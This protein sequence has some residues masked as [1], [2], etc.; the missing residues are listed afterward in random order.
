MFNI[1]S[2]LTITNSIFWLNEDSSGTN[3]SAQIF[4]GTPV[5]NYNCIQ[6]WTGLLGG[7]GNIGDDPMEALRYE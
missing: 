7:T 5:V 2:N 1:S 4:S 6:G 3:K